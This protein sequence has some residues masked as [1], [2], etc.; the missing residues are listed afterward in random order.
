MKNL[1]TLGQRISYLR[2]K[3]GLSQRRLMD[4]LG[5][6]NLSKYEKDKRE[7]KIDV[8]KAIADYFHVSIDWL[9]K[10]SEYIHTNGLSEREIQIIKQLRQLDKSEQIKIEGMIELKLVESGIY[11]LSIQKELN[12]ANP[13]KGNFHAK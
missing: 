10:G 11:T 6:E 13:N 3:C 1:E 12:S 9:L 4:E 5:F 2:T 7:P 8:L